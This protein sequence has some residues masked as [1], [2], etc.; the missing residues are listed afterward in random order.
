MSEFRTVDMLPFFESI[1]LHCGKAFFDKPSDRVKTT[2]TPVF[3]V[4]LPR[5]GST[6]LEQMLVQHS[7]VGTLGENTV[8]S[9]KIV[10]YLSKRN[11]AEF[12]AC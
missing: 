6:L 11:N 4:G 2:F 8:I 12:P 1:K 7:N 3:I 10:P 9:D 5:T